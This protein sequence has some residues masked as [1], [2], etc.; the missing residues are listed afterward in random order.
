MEFEVGDRVM[1]KVSPWKEVVR[2]GKWG[3]LNPRY[4][5]PF[6]VLAKVRK[7]SYRLELPQELSSVHH[8]FHVSNLKKCYADEP[9]VM[10]LE[11]IHVDD[12]LQFVEEPVEIMEQ[13]IK[14]LKRSRIPLVK[15][16]DGVIHLPFLDIF[17]ISRGL[18]TKCMSAK[19][20][21]WNDLVLPW[22]QL[23]SAL[24]QYTSPALTQNV[25][26]NMRRIG[27][28]FSG[29]DTPLFDGM[30]VQQQVQDVEDAAEDEDDDNEVS[31]EPTPPSPTPA[32]PSPSPTQE[33]IPS[34]PQAQTSQPSSPPQQKPSQT[35]DI[36]MT[37]LNTLLETCATLT[38]KVA[39]LE[40]DKIAQAIE[41]TKL[42]Q[43]H[44]DE[45][46]HAE[47]EEVIE[48]VTVSKL[49]TEV[50]TTAATTIT[51][52]QVPKASDPR[53]RRGVVIQDPKEI[54]TAS[55]IV[56]SDVKSKDKGKEILV[57][58]PKPLKRQAKIKQDEAFARE[59]EA[60]LNANINWNDVMDSGK[61]EHDDISQEHVDSRWT[62][63]KKGEKETEEEGN[64]RKG[65]SL[66]KD[67]AKKQRIDKETEELKTHLQIVV[68]DDDDVF[69]E[70]TP[71]ALKV[72]VVDYQI[73]MVILLEN[74][75]LPRIK[76]GLVHLNPRE[77]LSQ[78]THQPPMPWSLNVMALKAMIGV[79]KQ[80]RSLQIFLLWLFHQT[81]P[82]HL[83]I[84]SWPPSNLYDRF[85]PSGGYHV[86]PPPYTGTFMPPK[87]V[88]VFHTAPFA[89]TEHLAF[90]VQI[91]TTKPEQDLS[92]TS[93]PSAPIIE[94][95]VSD[96]EEDS[97]P[98]D[99]Q[100]SVSS[101]AQSSEPVKHPSHSSVDHL[102]KDYDFHAKKMAKP[103][104]RN[105]A[106][107]GYY[108]QYAPKPLQH[109][110][111]PA[112][113][114]H[115][116]SV[117]TTPVRPVSATLPNLHMTRPRQAYRVVTKSKSPIR[118]HLPPSPSLKHHNSPP[119]VTSAK[120][121]V[122]NPQQ[123]L[124]HKG[125]IDS[126][127]SRYMTGNM[128]YLSDFKELNGG[129]VSFG[130]NPKGGK[131]TGKGK[132]KTGKLDFDDVYFVKELK[133]NLFSL[134]EESQVL[135]R[136]P[137]EN[138][139]YNVNLKNV[140]PF[141]D[142]T[143]LFAKATID[144]SNL[145]HRRLGHISFKTI[146][147]LVKGNL[148]RGLP[149]KVFEND[150][151]CV[152]CKKGK[153]HRAFC[154]SK[155]VSSVDQPL[156][157]LHMD[158][159]GPTF[160]KS[161]KN[162]LSLKVKVIRSDNRTEFKNSDLN[163][164]CGIKGIKRVFSVPRTPQQNRAAERK[165]RTLIEAARTMLADLLLPIPFWAE[166]VNTACYVQNR[167]KAF[168]VFNSRTCI[169][170][171]T[172]HVNFLEN[173]PSVTRTGPTW[174]FDIDSLSWTMNYY[175]VTAGNQTNSGAGFQD[176]FDAEKARKEVTQTYV[177][178]PAWSAG[179]TNPQDN[180]KDALVDGKEHGVDI[181]K[182][183]SA[184][185][186][187]SS[188]S[189]QTRKQ[190]DK[191]EREDK[192]KSHV[193]S[194]TG[195][196]DL[197]T[198]FEECSN[199]SSNGVNAASSLVPTAGHNFINSTNNF[200]VAGP[201]NT[202]VS[203]TYENSSFQD[204]STSSHDPDMLALEDFT[205]SGDEA[206]V[207]AEA[208]I[209]NLESFI[210]VSPIPTT[211]IHKDHPISQIIG[212]LSLTTQ[213]RSMVRVVKEQGGLSLIFDKDFHTCMFACFLSQEEPKRIHQALKDPTIG[214]KWVY[215]NKKDER[216]I[217]IRNKARLVTQ[218]HIQEEGIDYKE[219]FA[220]VAKI[221]AIRLFL[222]YASFMGFLVYQM[223]VKSAFLY[224]TI[225]E[226]VYVCQ[227]PGFEDPDH[228]DKVYK[229]VK[230]LYGLHQA[231]RAWY[232]TL[233]T[234][235][236]EN[237]FQRGTIDQTLFIKKKK[238]DILLVQIYED[239]II[240]GAT[241]KDLCKS[242][243]KLM[244]DRFQMSS[245]GELTFFL[246]KSASTPIDAEK[247][248]LKDPDGEDVDVHTYRSMICSLMSLTSSRPDIV[249][250]C[251]KQTVVANLSTEAEYVAA[252]SGCAQV[253]WIQ[254]QLLDYGHTLL[255]FCLINWCCSVSVVRLLIKQSTD[256]T[257][258]QA[259]VDKK[260]VVISEAVIREVLRLDDAEG[261]DCLPKE[262]IFTGLARMGYEKPIGKG[263][264][265]VEKPLF[266]GMLVVR[267]DVEVDIGEE[268]I[269]DDTAI[270]A[271]QEVVTTAILED[272]ALD[273]CAA[274]TLRV[275]HLEHAKEAQTLEI[276]QLKKRV[277]K[278]ERVNKVKTFTLRRL[279]KVGTSQRVKTS[280]DTIIEDVSNQ[281]R[282]IVELDRDKGV[283]LIGEKEKTKEV[284]DI[285]DNA[286]VEGRQAEKQ[287]EI[288][289]ID[290]DHPSK[291]LSMQE[292]DSEVQEAVEVVTTT[293]LITE[294]VNA[295]S[296]PVS[297]ASIIIPTAK[298]IILAA[299]P[300]I[301]AVTI[302]VVLVKVVAAS[303]RR[304]RGVV[305]R[306]PEEESSAKTSDET[307]SKDKGKGILVE[308]PKPMKKKKQVE[309][310]EAYARKLHEELN[311]NIDWDVAIDHEQIEEE[312]SRALE[313]INETPAQKAAK[314]RRLNQEDKDVE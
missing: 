215:K 27:R 1:L 22:L 166:V 138:N 34:P 80:R 91:S 260:Q 21:A 269:P 47:V 286:Q 192:G 46:E 89:E 232:E 143:C 52:V 93:R 241:S 295:A 41:I 44:I 94:D 163:Q 213:I 214:T 162:Q 153:Q 105:C 306:D 200:S 203:P 313:S 174:L 86:V 190:A 118:R 60:E 13:E 304:R 61:K 103:A 120:T 71:L 246:G 236:L 208:D 238:G 237:G 83:L 227:P 229:M 147:K 186:P 274:L 24:P 207:G 76:E 198:E 59:L 148:V 270:A 30:L 54:A 222:A 294:V 75:D 204:A 287:A 280:N 262:E 8:T 196:R 130:G 296:T 285:V 116:Q 177:L 122:G 250:A 175:P 17:I 141:R 16:F 288:Y 282:M 160:V 307:K 230:A 248:L 312:E 201:S 224:G 182:S 194:F 108:K 64:K 69:T 6:K 114:P 206:V 219:V 261:V 14:R 36:L 268:Q 283:E 298:Q 210:P 85:V 291:V 62:S 95:W 19:R 57:K 176:S 123:A 77:G 300:N 66:N 113:L 310:D 161:L 90:N 228:P 276:T 50:V 124:Q 110:I 231:P 314:R 11:G 180:D 126:G 15:V 127:C 184:D 309:I 78:L 142:L 150:H 289:Q 253:L 9:L 301:P 106:N 146:N 68:N 243:E 299:E 239:D 311:Q 112:V 82:A 96:S 169:V 165:N 144:K 70:A 185:I 137:R 265:G 159:F 281:R 40:Q 212:D 49:M 279:K 45:A 173:K 220:P 101:F 191:T 152:A 171:E 188:S 183:L 2:F 272:T 12:M 259:L 264:S 302:T 37:L 35:T 197:N 178:F 99:P 256:V 84:M 308:D 244:K 211:R 149:T 189:A 18:L 252:A 42:K 290:L 158:L 100:Q 240:F 154:K 129:Y 245:I 218:G 135:L 258:L 117:L 181:Q 73:R 4:V 145:W 247:P 58:E 254:N 271:A 292:D 55:V 221:K 87:P 205:Y 266:E 10:P 139:M 51:T 102:I 134:P 5:E 53:R 131:I 235:L 26:A 72:P 28:G 234:Y 263:L 56:H 79:I 97:N 195:Y 223:D 257:R 168:R 133:F 31:T 29:V 172:L 167:I 242:F 140:V 104:Q 136:I 32:T 170:Q 128:P 225:E 25:F 33:H 20:T 23:S 7:V 111:P 226:E 209:N 67:A 109:S 277:K 273:A 193:E 74:V 156:F 164:L 151:S 267:E 88:L 275:E 155:P 63:S 132:I 65:D 179:F 121:L 199:N 43:R 119:K 187:S 216:G 81:H 48:V 38:K 249:F 98:Y 297:V 125:V 115:S 305:I 3:K 284:K 92:H 255:L 303:T 293:K 157:R 217:V 278:L 107:R 233:A 39:N 251:K 202:A